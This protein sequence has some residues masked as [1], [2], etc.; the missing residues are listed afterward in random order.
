M[1]LTNIQ[2]QNLLNICSEF[3]LFFGEIPKAYN[4]QR[5]CWDRLE[6][7]IQ[8]KIVIY[9]LSSQFI[10][11]QQILLIVG[12]ATLHGYKTKPILYDEDARGAKV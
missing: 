9:T 7:D 10:D 8:A 2:L 11:K 4:K 3:A 6:I 12:I 1:D 5:I